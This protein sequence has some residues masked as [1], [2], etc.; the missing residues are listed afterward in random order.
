M[1]S[2]ECSCRVWSD[3]LEGVAA[4]CREAGAKTEVEAIDVT[5]REAM[6]RSL[7]EQDDKH[8]ID[9]V[10]ANAGVSASMLRTPG[11]VPALVV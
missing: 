9:L 4:R 11:G 7:L 6:Q 3:K 8:P 10:I 5:D 2:T 1:L